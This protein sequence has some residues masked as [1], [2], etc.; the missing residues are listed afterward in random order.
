[1]L[2]GGYATRLKALTKN[3]AKALLEINNQTVLDIVFDNIKT[4]TVDIDEYI[5]VTNDTFYDDFVEWKNKQDIDT[6][7]VISDGSTCN[8]NKVGAGSALLKTIE[9]L[10]ICDDIFVVAGD[11]I[12]D[13]SLKYIFEDFKMSTYS[14]L[15]YYNEIDIERLKRTGI[16]EIDENNIVISMEEKPKFPKTNYAVPPFYWLK[17]DDVQLLLKLFKDSPKIDSMGFIM[18]ELCKYTKVSA[19]KMKG[20]RYSVGT[21]G[22]YN[23]FLK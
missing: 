22:E 21:I 12:L 13:F 19:K 6:I 20:K 8:Q 9:K 7:K 15:M 16:I 23:D 1:M 17:K 11:N 4:S 3:K 5:L 10:N 2:V 18:C 14:N